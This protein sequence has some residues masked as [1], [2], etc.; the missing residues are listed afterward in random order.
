MSCKLNIRARTRSQR[1]D[2]AGTRV[3]DN[4]TD[5]TTNL[6]QGYA[7]IREAATVCDVVAAASDYLLEN[8]KKVLVL[9]GYRVQ[10]V[11]LRKGRPIPA[12]KFF[13]WPRLWAGSGQGPA[14]L[15]G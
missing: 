7:N 12:N 11:I 2:I 14:E 15:A 4:S 9:C 1:N 5:V 13:C 6:A 8:R 10:Q 3:G